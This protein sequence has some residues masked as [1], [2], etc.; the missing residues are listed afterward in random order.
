MKKIFILFL[1][2]S[3]LSFLSIASTLHI[4]AGEVNYGIGS[5]K[6][7]IID[8]K[9]IIGDTTIA[10]TYIIIIGQKDYSGNVTW[11]NAQATGD[12]RI[13]MKNATATAK[14][15]N[16]D[17]SNDVGTLSGSAS[18]TIS[19]SGGMISIQASS[20]QFNT[21]T[22]FYTGQ[23]SPVQITKGDTYIEGKQFT[24]D[25]QKGALDITGNVYLYNKAT[26]EKA[27]SNELVMN[28]STNKI[29]L[30]KVQM[31]IMIGS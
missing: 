10:A 16:Y 11:T 18:M 27:Y 22:S 21:K 1:L 3:I 23:G 25:S 14:S 24:Y 15:M 7:S 9:I 19:A 30:K 26:G 6:T 17:L 4:V 2:I 28:T 13:F 31:E 12:V 29:I 8:G 20:L 5:T